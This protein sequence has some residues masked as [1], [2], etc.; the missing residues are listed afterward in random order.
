MTLR[1]G[2]FGGT[3]DPIHLGHLLVA[4]VA[5]QI[6]DLHRVLFVP[7]R[8][9]PHKGEGVASPEQR[10]RM[11]AL[12]CEPNPHFEVSDVEI[13]R[14]GPSYTVDTVRVLR[15]QSPSGAE[16]FLMLGA[17]SA[18]DFGSWKDHESL[19]NDAKIVVLG[20]PGVGEDTV[21]SA[22]ASRL[23]FLR[24][25]LLEISSSDIRRRVNSGASIRYMVTDAVN[26]Y[27]RVERLY[28]PG[29]DLS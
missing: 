6:L 25:P 4:E 23:T 1:L 16:F 29:K 11:T 5:R 9:P 14:E 13:R 27:I 17:D 8:V 2:V 15:G 24:T 12:A 26:D 20:R 19:L 21:P 18:R 7:A 3:F 10:Y 22:F 28:G